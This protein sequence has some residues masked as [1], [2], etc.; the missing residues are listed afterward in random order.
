MHELSVAQSIL[1]ILKNEA[2]INGY[3]SI[4]SVTVEAGE[5]TG[6]V[7]VSLELC[8]EIAAK[9][10][11]ADGASIEIVTLPITAGCSDCGKDFDIVGRAFECPHCESTSFKVTGGNELRIVEIDV[12]DKTRRARTA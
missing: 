11:I 7:P 3:D 4:D 5:M 2:A 12:S 6:I 10:T 8:F 1:D 9:D